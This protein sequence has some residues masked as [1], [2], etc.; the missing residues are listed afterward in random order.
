[1]LRDKRVTSALIGASR[2]EQIV[3]LVGALK[4]PDFSAAELAAI[5]QH[6]V[7]GGLNLWKRPS[8]DQRRA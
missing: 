7:D 8:T 4:R 5:D 6:A 1:M 2:P 3:G